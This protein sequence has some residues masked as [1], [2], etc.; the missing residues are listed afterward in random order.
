MI[1]ILFTIFL[2]ST[3]L[4]GATSALEKAYAKGRS[5]AST[6]DKSTAPVVKI[7]KCKYFVLLEKTI[8]AKMRNEAYKGCEDEIYGKKN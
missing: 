7:Q 1:K 8:S 4:F 5:I 2:L 6:I 3:V